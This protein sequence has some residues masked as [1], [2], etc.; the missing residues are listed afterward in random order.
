MC[1]KDQFCPAVNR[2]GKYFNSVL[3]AVILNQAYGPQTYTENSELV[4]SMDATDPNQ[5]AAFKI[6]LEQ[7]LLNLS[8]FSRWLNLGRNSDSIRLP[9]IFNQ[10]HATLTELGEEFFQKYILFGG[11]QATDIDENPEEE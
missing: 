1:T 9:K 3:Q 4:V 8:E 11:S 5:Q 2:G 7:N 10:H 6:L